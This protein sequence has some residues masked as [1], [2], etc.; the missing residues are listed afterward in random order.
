MEHEGGGSLINHNDDGDAS[1]SSPE[2]GHLMG[3]IPTEPEERRAYFAE[4]G[5]AGGAATLATYGASHFAALGKVGFAVT[6]GRYGGDFVW[7]LLRDSYLRKYPDRT[8]P[9]HRATDAA[10]QKD[11]LRAEARRLYTDPQPCADCGDPGM[12][13]D[14]VHGVLAGNDPANVAWHC[15]RCHANKTR[16]ERRVRWG[17]KEDPEL[18]H[19]ISSSWQ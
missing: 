12:Q 9:R 3:A 17:T 6:L 15:D 10:R 1:S 8:G 7:R 19:A 18:R 2:R 11:R 13:R 14:H 5:R 16:V 4:L